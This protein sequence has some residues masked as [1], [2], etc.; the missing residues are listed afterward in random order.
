MLYGRIN[1]MNKEYINEDQLAGKTVF[2]IALD[3]IKRLYGDQK[4]VSLRPNQLSSQLKY[5]FDS[6]FEGFRSAI[7]QVLAAD[8][9]GDI[10][11]QKTYEIIKKYN[12]LSSYLKNVVNMKQLSP[13]DEEA[14]KK[15]FDE[16]KDKLELLKQIAIDNNFL[17]REDIVDMVN[18]INKT[19]KVP[20]AEL[21]KVSGTTASMTEAVQDKNTSV[22]RIDDAIIKLDNI[23]Q[24]LNDPNIQNSTKLK[25]QQ[26][27]TKNLYDFFVDQNLNPLEFAL[28]NQNYDA[29]NNLENDIKSDIQ[30]FISTKQVANDKLQELQDYEAKKEYPNVTK[31][32][33]KQ[34]INNKINEIITNET[35]LLT[36]A[37]SVLT[38]AEQKDPVNIKKLETDINAVE[39][40]WNTEEKKL[41]K[42]A[43]NDLTARKQQFY[44]KFKND[45][46]NTNT[47]LGN[48]DNL[49]ENNLLAE[50][51][52]LDKLRDE[53][54]TQEQIDLNAITA[55]VDKAI[56]AI[57]TTAAPIVQPKIK[58]SKTVKI[59]VPPQLTSQAVVN[60]IYKTL[61]QFETA[62]KKALAE[63]E[64]R[65][66]AKQPLL[67]NFK[68]KN[69]KDPSRLQ[70]AIKNKWK[71][72]SKYDEKIPSQKVLKE[73]YFT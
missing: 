18:N 59:K 57:L 68:G 72:Y 55:D 47:A 48:N 33:L 66:I 22:K 69:L 60:P 8:Y 46:D 17:D 62:Y 49:D 52:E 37:F 28:I 35:K 45:I 6:L 25:S 21:Q 2:K 16:L 10:T 34:T 30:W 5:G 14:I 58:K 26:D 11:T 3:Q 65:T 7:E 1:K 64:A 61:S 54:L 40:T 53:I 51:N 39:T 9:N 50:I 23:D 38:E 56:Q 71:I 70:N 63:N 41:Y 42:M 29:V 12:Q 4:E 43:K 20:K 15:L 31:G 67:T 36:D 13:E 32:V 24:E 19:T 73:T 27:E 44:T